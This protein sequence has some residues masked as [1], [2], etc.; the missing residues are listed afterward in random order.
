MQK[1]KLREKTYQFDSRGDINLGYDVTMWRSEGGKIHVHDVVA[2]YHPQNNNFTHTNHN[3]IQQL[4]DLK[5]GPHS[6][7]ILYI[8]TQRPTHTYC[9]VS[10]L[11]TF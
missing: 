10:L 2:E 1:F 3:T 9:S 11:K 6:A 8:Y 5:V 4:W 7:V